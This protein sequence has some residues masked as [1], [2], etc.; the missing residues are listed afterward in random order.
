MGV[1]GRRIPEK[2]LCELCNPRP[3][4]NTCERAKQI[5]ETKLAKWNRDKE[6]RRRNV[7]ENRKRKSSDDSDQ[8]KNAVSVKHGYQLIDTNEYTE[9]IQRLIDS[10][11]DT[12]D[13]HLSMKQYKSCQV[14]FVA[15][16]TQGI[17][18][19]DAISPNEEVAEYCGRVCDRNE[20]A[21]RDSIGPHCLI[22]R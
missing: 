6:R 20:I 2:Y 7:R 10:I 21:A 8:P 15:P 18:A 17:V 1:D 22:Y 3:L 11:D 14:M 19:T 5:Q 9:S 4:K 16:A 13:K 12:D